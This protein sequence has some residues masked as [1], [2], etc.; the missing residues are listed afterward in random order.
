MTL[1]QGENPSLFFRAR[2]LVH[3]NMD[4]GAT[5]DYTFDALLK[6]FKNIL[7]VS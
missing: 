7:H 1:P 6:I 3:A 2:M 5:Y 4:K